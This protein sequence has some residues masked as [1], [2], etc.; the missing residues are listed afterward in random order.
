MGAP[1]AALLRAGPS[2]CFDSVQGSYR[3]PFGRFA[4]GAAMGELNTTF[5]H[6]SN[7]LFKRVVQIEV[8]GQNLPM[9]TEQ[10]HGETPAHVLDYVDQKSSLSLEVARK[11]YDDLHER[12]YK[13]ATLL[14]GGGGSVGAYAVSKLSPLSEY[15]AWAPLAALAVT[16]FVIAAH[17]IWVAATSREVSPGNGPK[18]LL[19]YYS[20][21]VKDGWSEEKA[22]TITREQEL[23][24]MQQRLRAYAN[25]CNIRADAIDCAYKAV[26]IASPLV[27][28]ATAA[29]LRVFGC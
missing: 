23:E 5:K 3:Y 14:V 12:A 7:T 10:Q 6:V 2:S 22:F 17:L 20:A 18:N 15:M 29:V 28:L 26:A 27:P 24:L 25:G 21:R 4:F 19:G 16:W 11:S 1:S 13:L 9:T 8:M